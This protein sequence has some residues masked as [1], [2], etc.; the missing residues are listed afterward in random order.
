MNMNGED[1]VPYMV[2]YRMCRAVKTK[3]GRLLSMSL[4]APWHDISAF[5][6]AIPK[7]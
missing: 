2:G 5:I 4:I 6:L 7:T 1:V 3:T